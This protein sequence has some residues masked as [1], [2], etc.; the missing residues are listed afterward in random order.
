MMACPSAVRRPPERP[1]AAFGAAGPHRVENTPAFEPLAGNGLQ[2]IAARRIQ[3]LGAAFD[4]DDPVSVV[5]QSR[6]QRRPRDAAAD[7]RKI[8]VQLFGVGRVLLR[9]PRLP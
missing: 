3:R 4:Q 6:G 5:G 8:A 9:S 1:E 2:V 7:D